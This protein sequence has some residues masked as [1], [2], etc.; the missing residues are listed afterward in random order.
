[1]DGS[2]QICSWPN[3]RLIPVTC[4]YSPCSVRPPSR[5]ATISSVHQRWQKRFLPRRACGRA[6]G[7]NTCDEFAALMCL[8]CANV[9]SKFRSERLSEQPR[10]HMQPCA[11]RRCNVKLACPL[12]RTHIVCQ[13]AAA[14]LTAAAELGSGCRVQQQLKARR[15]QHAT[16]C[17]A[18]GDTPERTL[19]CMRSR[20][21][22]HGCTITPGPL[23]QISTMAHFIAVISQIEVVSCV[24]WPFGLKAFA[25]YFDFHKVTRSGWS[26]TVYGKT[27][28]PSEPEETKQLHTLSNMLTPSLWST[29]ISVCKKNVPHNVPLISFLFRKTFFSLFFFWG[30]WVWNNEPRCFGV[31]HGR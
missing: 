16:R 3:K 18:A 11:R 29:K 31:L 21:E 9:A 2:L 6:Q 14:A 23:Q 7:A 19:V 25:A 28:N 22:P 15:T 20:Y 4:L 13:R 5:G 24:W 12:S 26:F 10:L 17:K 8:Q 1:M 30:K 27:V